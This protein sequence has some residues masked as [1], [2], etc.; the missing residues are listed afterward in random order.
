MKYT[1]FKFFRN[2]PLTNLAKSMNFESNS[3]RDNFFDSG[4]YESVDYTSYN[5]NMVRDR[6]TVRVDMEFDK[7]LGLN[8]CYFIDERSGIRYY[9]QI[10]RTRYINEKVTEFTLTVDVLMTFFQGD[11]SSKVGYVNISRQHLTQDKYN[12]NVF[13]L[14]SGDYMSTSNPRIIYQGFMPFVSDESLTEKKTLE[15]G[16]TYYEAKT[17]GLGLVIQSSAD[18][19]ANFGDIDAPKLKTSSGSVYDKVTSPVNLYYIKMNDANSLFDELSD[20]PWIEQ[21]IKSIIIIP[22]KFIDSED[23]SSVSGKSISTNTL[24]KF[25][26]SK[27]NNLSSLDTTQIEITQDFLKNFFQTKYGFDIISNE[28]HL[29]NSNYFNIYVTNWGGAQ[30]QIKPQNLSEH[31]LTWRT[32]GVIGYDNKVMFNVNRYNEDEENLTYQVGGAT[33]NVQIPVPR[34]EYQGASLIISSWDTMPILIDNYKMSLARS[35][36]DRSLTQE[37]TLSGQWDIARGA[38]EN[39]NSTQDRLLAALNLVGSADVSTLANN[40]YAEYNYYRELEAKQNQ[41]KISQPSITSQTTGNAMSIRNNVFGISVKL[42]GC[43]YNDL[44]LAYRYHKATG[45]SWKMYDQL[46]SV[47]SMS[48][49]NYVQFDGDWYMD[50]IPSEFMQIAKSLFSGGVSLY[51]NPQRIRNPF[52]VNIESNTR[53]I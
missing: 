38:N 10:T 29:Y 22:D 50:N 19:S 31:S 26:N 11:F 25:K 21:N 20:Y 6:L 35:A 44:H 46:E 40:Y 45:Y 53:I 14:A 5:Y 15:N 8:Y 16:N 49:V 39:R 9:C 42:Y 7:H 3:S 37:N 34:G 41:D 28:P 12:N 23:L 2:T 36:Y 47:R 51:H 33:G 48:I 30:V 27:L 17:D 4:I 32:S 24:K 18:L 1:K 52:N 13:K 43:S